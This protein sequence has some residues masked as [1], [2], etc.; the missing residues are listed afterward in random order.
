M[1]D[2]QKQFLDRATSEA[3]KA[4][5]PFAQMAACEAALESNWGQVNSPA[6]PTIYS[7]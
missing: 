4:N 6:K 3:V 1:N 5:H 7:A 2:L